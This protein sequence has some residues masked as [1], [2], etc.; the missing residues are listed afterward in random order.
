VLATA[1]QERLFLC[2]ERDTCVEEIVAAADAVG[3]K[4]R[5]PSGNKLAA[6]SIPVLRKRNNEILSQPSLVRFEV[7]KVVNF[8][9]DAGSSKSSTFKT[10]QLIVQGDA[11]VEVH[12]SMRTVISWP[13]TALLAIVR[14]DW[15]P[16]RIV[17][18]FAREE[19]LA[20]R[21][22]ARDQLIALLL[23]G[24]REAGLPL[25]PVCSGEFDRSRFFHPH[26]ADSYGSG[27]NRLIL[28]VTFRQTLG[29]D[30]SAL[31]TIL[32]R[33]AEH[34][35]VEWTR[36]RGPVD[37]LV[38][39]RSAQAAWKTTQAGKELVVKLVAGSNAECVIARD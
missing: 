25:V 24:R 4:L 3:V 26:T 33:S 27:G 7:K 15:D 23:L 6:M 30:L 5:R 18:E 8:A 37:R 34:R 35:V 29:S 16:K 32:P 22:D 38:M 10:I 19:S 13:F 39:H 21:M 12:R 17:F 11:L 14:P 9:T 2:I 20:V 36:P 31:E 1:F 28:P